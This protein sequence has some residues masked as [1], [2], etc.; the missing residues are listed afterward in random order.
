MLEPACSSRSDTTPSNRRPPDGRCRRPGPPIA[1][2][3]PESAV[4]SS[5]ARCWRRT[6]AACSRCRSAAAGW[7]GSHPTRAPSS[8]STASPSHVHC[9]AA[10]VAMTSVVTR[11]SAT[12]SSSAPTRV[13]PDRGSP[14]RSCGRTAGCTP[15]AGRTRSSRS[16]R[17]ASSSGVSTEFGSAD[18]FAGEAMFHHARDASKVA[19]V[20][21][22]DWL[23]TT[24]GRLLDVQW[25]TPH[26]AS[27][28]AITIG[29]AEY[30]D[31]LADAVSEV[32]GR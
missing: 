2:G 32:E 30:L 17:V 28:G 29:R 9:N 11:G 26:L 27:L 15:S 19:L 5:L 12:S 31:R 25:L 23:T 24:G 7:R 22:V 4:T 21:L 3:S 8:R 18:F 10:H 14:R 1:T 6:V 16:T 13:V 20:G